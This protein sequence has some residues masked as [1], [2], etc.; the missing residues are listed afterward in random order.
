MV[1]LTGGSSSQIGFLD[2]LTSVYLIGL[3]IGNAAAFL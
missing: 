2:G 1:S 3:T